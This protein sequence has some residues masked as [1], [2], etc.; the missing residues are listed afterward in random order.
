MP[1]SR[2]L[3]A[4]IGMMGPAM[5]AG[6]AYLDPGNVAANITAGSQ[7]GYLLVWVVV[8]GNS[9]AWLVQYLSASLGIATGLSLPEVLGKRIRSRAARILYWVQGELV[10]MATDIA[11]IV[12]GAVALNLLFGLP[13][14]LGGV[15][16]G[17]VA[18]LVLSVHS[19]IGVRPFEAV[20]IS[21]VGVIAVGFVAGV[22]VSPVDPAQFVAGLVPR[23]EGSDSILLAAAILG[24]T[25]M[26]HAI[27]AHS[28]FSRDRFGQVEPRRI[29][30]LLRATRFDVT[31]ALALA[32]GV[33]IA[34]LML[35]ASA[36]HGVEGTDSLAGAYSAIATVLG[37]VIATVFA[38]GLLASALASTAVGAYAGS[39]IMAG[40]L[41]WQ[42]PVSIRR[43]VTIIPA[44]AL[45]SFDVE[46]TGAL[47]LSQV[48]L[49]FGI[50]FALV[51]LVVLT[52]KR[53]LM[54]DAKSSVLVRTLA[55]L[56]TAVVIAFNVWLLVLTLA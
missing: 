53:E 39:E 25:V 49:S 33:N 14:P 28:G 34:L 6:V 55:S 4:L 23:L 19:R 41:K 24:A 43:A 20:I 44:I 48:I 11:E 10:A 30:A 54:G 31:A 7:F 9:M 21:L 51:P 12:G 35:G 16:T 56:A 2:K 17:V 42:F 40:L 15:I 3:G 45:L 50:P 18:L 36:L 29:P 38:I 5:V 46:P 22:V 13:L 52:G 26:P 1:E 47:V 32:G 37:P 8:L 27:Y